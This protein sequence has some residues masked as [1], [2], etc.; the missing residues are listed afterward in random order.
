MESLILDVNWLAVCVGAV[1]SYALGAVWYSEKLF[2]KKW[3][4]G[5]GT[6]AVP[7]ASMTL[8]MLTQAGGTFL[9]AW[10][11]GITETTNSLP[12]AILIVFTIAGL[13]K[14]NGFFAGK[15]K[16]AISVE[17]MFVLVMAAIMIG[18]HAVL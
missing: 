6:P 5:I 4:E 1:L 13:I 14:A 12:F 10:V 18:I 8:A 3:R 15:T 16:Y 17:V 2:A 9:L 7:N 11:I